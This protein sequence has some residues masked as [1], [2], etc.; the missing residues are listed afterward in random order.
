MTTA[1]PVTTVAVEAAAVVIATAGKHPLMSFTPPLT[2]PIATTLSGED[3]DN[4]HVNS[5]VDNGNGNGSGG[6]PLIMS[7]TAHH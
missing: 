3:E 4:D 2:M 1:P 7:S 6:Y 5:S